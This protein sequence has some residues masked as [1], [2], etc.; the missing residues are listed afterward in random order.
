MKETRGRPK[1]G[2]NRKYSYEF[3]LK[4][5][6]ENLEEKI[7]INILEKKYKISDSVILKWVHLYLEGKEDSLKN[8]G[9]GRGNHFSALHTSK[10][11][12]EIERLTLELMKRDIEIERLKKGYTVKGVGSKKEYVTLS[13]K[14]VK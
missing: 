9:K 12:S 8:M 4:V 6:K 14:T 13:G 7:S 10:N 11:L 1:G 5:V 2:K 3:K